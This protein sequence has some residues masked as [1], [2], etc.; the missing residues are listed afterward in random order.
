M[1]GRII[2]VG[3][4]LMQSVCTTVVLHAVWGEGEIIQLDM[5]SF[6]KEDGASSVLGTEEL[7]GCHMGACLSAIYPL[8]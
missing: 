2:V 8:W 6:G 3:V 7:S 5:W 1:D 4:S